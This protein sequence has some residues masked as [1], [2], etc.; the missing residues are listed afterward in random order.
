MARKPETVF[1]GSVHRHIPRVVHREKMANP[2]RGG[3]ADVWYSARKQDLW[4][5]YK[6]VPTIPRTGVAANL[7]QLQL[8]WLN[9]RHAE[10][11]NVA[12]IIGCPC[13]GVILRDRA[14]EHR[15]AKTEFE[16]KLL[17]REELARWITAFTLG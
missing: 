6:F 3:T 15:V 1:I 2:Y 10:G 5:E 17:S 16:K 14:W 4:S 7:S 12:V 13:G 11:R 9:N 8:Q